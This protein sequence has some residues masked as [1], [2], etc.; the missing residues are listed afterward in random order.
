MPQTTSLT[1]DLAHWPETIAASYPRVVLSPGDFVGGP[2][3][4]FPAAL[5]DLDPDVAYA[6]ADATLQRV[7]ARTGTRIAGYKISVASARDQASINATEPVLGALTNEQLRPSGAQIGLDLANSPLLEPEIAMRT[8]R[9]L[10]PEATLEEIAGG[11][12]LTAAIEVPT[13]RFRGWL[14]AD[15]PGVIGVGG[16]IADNAV[17]GCVVLADR[18][19]PGI[20]PEAMERVTV[21]LTLPDGGTVDGHA[22]NVIGGPYAAMRWLVGKLGRLGRALPVGSIV[23]SGTLAPPTRVVAGRYVA[24]FDSGLGTSSVTFS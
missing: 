23:S 22:L 5:N 19:I 18:W 6:V 13:S 14:P 12:E 3:D 20:S 2:L 4:P 1:D 21:R 8:V 24:T 15:G 10:T 16:L 17:A 7:V 9:E 11:V